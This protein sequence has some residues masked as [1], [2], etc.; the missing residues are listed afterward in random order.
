MQLAIVHY[1]LNRGGVTQVI[2]NQLRALS[3]VHGD[4]APLKVVI[5]Y[6]G[7]GAGWPDMEAAPL[8]GLEVT[9][10]TV[11]DLEYT[12][13]GA[14]PAVTLADNLIEAFGR[15]GLRPDDTIVHIHNH[16]L[17]KTPSLPA[18]VAELSS[19]GF[20]L[21][22]Q[23]HDFVEDFRP[24]NYR[25]L[26]GALA[27]ESAAEL[28][29]RIYPQGSAIHYA[30]LN[31]RDYRIL[32]EAGVGAKRLHAL[33]NP[34][35]QFSGLP[36]RGAARSK[37][38]ERYGVGN[39]D[40]YVLY[41]VRGIRRKNLG[42]FLLWGAASPE[43]TCF[44]LTLPPLNPVER[45]RYLAWKRL[46]EAL[47][48]PVIFE[49]GAAGGLEFGE[50]LMAAD[51]ILTTSVAE[52][53]GMVFL[54][55]WL[56]RRELMGRD[57]P[58]ITADFVA[59]GLEFSKLS[60]VVKIPSDWVGTRR[61][62]KEV[63]E[64]YASV[65]DAYGQFQLDRERI[66]QEVCELFSTELLDFGRCSATL[67]ESIVSQ[68]VRDPRCRQ[69]FRQLNPAFDVSCEQRSKASADRISRNAQL[70]R[71]QYSLEPSG[72]RLQAL[73]RTVLNSPRGHQYELSRG[74][75]ILETFLSLQR[76]NP[77]RID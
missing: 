52:G 11:P 51:R 14:V 28:A 40:V 9:L 64:V 59:A 5:F 63:F 47:E 44:A 21:L 41:P 49:A 69:E 31:G 57:L 62:R 18:A 75:L 3:T 33:P 68:L 56:A 25:G 70:V 10:E 43:N 26:A 71:D 36:E 19:R 45:P 6:G 61:V 58:E 4:P 35:P 77:V 24:D 67:Q 38:A 23:M 66:Y 74:S 60:D 16:A 73:Y 20:A 32:A 15:A 46:A 65:L 17:G 34:V 50:N 29:E 53:F 72:V 27:T 48:L 22:L 37:L 7:G 12:P 30:V 13:R 42:E 55:S 1:H 39:D 76:F 54:E 8:A 2:W